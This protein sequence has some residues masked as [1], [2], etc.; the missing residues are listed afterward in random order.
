MCGEALPDDKDEQKAIFQSIKE[1]EFD[2]FMPDGVQYKGPMVPSLKRLILEQ[3][4]MWTSRD[5]L[6]ASASCMEGFKP[7]AW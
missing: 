4:S 3:V 6:G 5:V 1:H 2:L 7:L